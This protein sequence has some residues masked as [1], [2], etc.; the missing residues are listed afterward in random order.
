MQKYQ[1][2]KT[3]NQLPAGFS[4]TRHHFNDPQHSKYLLKF[5]PVKNAATR[6]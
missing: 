3:A 2:I 6:R 1:K 5:E 4:S